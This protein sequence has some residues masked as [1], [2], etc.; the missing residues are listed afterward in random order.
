MT[1]T[2]LSL[3]TDAPELGCVQGGFRGLAASFRGRLWQVVESRFPDQATPLLLGSTAR[4]RLHV[5]LQVDTPA[6]SHLWVWDRLT[7]GASTE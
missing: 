7:S 4:R 1:C 5:Q 6:V 3:L 2:E